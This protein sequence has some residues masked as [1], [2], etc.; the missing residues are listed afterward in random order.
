MVHIV[1][2]GFFLLW[3]VEEKGNEKQELPALTTQGMSVSRAGHFSLCRNRNEHLQTSLVWEGCFSSQGRGDTPR[4]RNPCCASS[5]STLINATQA[6]TAVQETHSSG[7]QSSW[8]GVSVQDKSKLTMR[9]EIWQWNGGLVENDS[10]S[11]T[12]VSVHQKKQPAAVN[13]KALQSDAQVTSVR[14]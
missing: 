3:H 6:P 10:K 13:S 9:N 4:I 7:P 12:C 11:V 1:G 2:M 8:I 14:V 5:G